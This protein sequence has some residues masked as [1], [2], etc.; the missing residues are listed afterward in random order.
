MPRPHHD[1]PRASSG[2][3]LVELAGVGQLGYAERPDAFNAAVLEFL[4]GLE[5]G[6]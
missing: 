6:A 3:R 5:R 2:A 4:D 1:E